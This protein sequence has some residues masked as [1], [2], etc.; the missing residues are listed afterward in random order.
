MDKI[1]FKNGATYEQYMGKWS[2]L[3]G[4]QFLDWLGGAPG[5]RWLD[6]GC[7]NGAFTELIAQHAHPTAV[8]G[9]DPSEP[10]LAY[11][12]NRTNL[13]TADL[14]QGDAAALP[15]ADN[16][17]DTA[18]MPLVIFFVPEPI[19]GVAEMARVVRP[20]GV[21]GAYAWDMYGGGFPYYS[22][23]TEMRAMGIAIPTPP[24]PEASR[25]EVMQTLWT[26]VGLQQVATNQIRV[27]RTFTNFDAYWQ[28]VLGAPSVGPAL[29]SLT[30]DQI[31]QL[32]ARM[33]AVLPTDGS[34]QLV[35]EACANAVKGI[36]PR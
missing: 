2:Q 29:A 1:Q 11:A 20:G 5:L 36:V 13:E 32:Q 34:G 14:R 9:V 18:V 17:F 19:K 15:F 12:R 35:S 24:S 3:V 33:T 25:L 30:A 7:G 27:R 21:V 10:Q 23:Q 31:V 28:T 16:S 4:Q 6:V 22:L 26:A 8:A